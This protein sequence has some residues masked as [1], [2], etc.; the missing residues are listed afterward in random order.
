MRIESITFVENEGSER[1]WRLEAL[2]LHSLNLIVGRNA[3]GKSRILNIILFLADLIRGR[4]SPSIDSASWDLRLANDNGIRY[5]L[6]TRD[7]NVTRET[8]ELGGRE[9]LVR[10]QD[11]AGTIYAEEL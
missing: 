10:K 11:G 7:G 6:Q 3:T 4:R 2:N 9:L 5:Q 1:E 8:F